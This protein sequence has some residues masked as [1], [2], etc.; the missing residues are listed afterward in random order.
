MLAS[1]RAGE[2]WHRTSSR[3]TA[4][5]PHAPLPNT[6]RITANSLILP[7]FHVMTDSEQDAVVEAIVAASGMTEGATA[8]ALG[9][10]A[11]A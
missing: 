5:F 2:S 10:R 8:G 11:G 6:E 4:E 7:L 9:L 3:R 1:P